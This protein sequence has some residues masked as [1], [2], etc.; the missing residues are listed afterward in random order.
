MNE[1]LADIGC[2]KCEVDELL[3]A[4][5]IDA[6]YV[7]TPSLPIIVINRRAITEL[8]G[9]TWVLLT[10][11]VCVVDVDKFVV[12]NVLDP[13]ADREVASLIQSQHFSY[14]YRRNSRVHKPQ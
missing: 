10:G 2:D 6:R 7:G 4:F 11:T 14:R 5:D 1:C 9:S 3:D 13:S 12:I 8:D